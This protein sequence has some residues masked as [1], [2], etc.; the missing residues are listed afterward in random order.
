MTVEPATLLQYRANVRLYILSIMEAHD[1][2]EQAIAGLT[3]CDRG[4][5]QNILA[6]KS[7]QVSTAESII[8]ALN[9]RFPRQEPY[10]AKATV[11]RCW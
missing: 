1:L 5:I 8:M 11:N 10:D 3:T 9:Q 2:S 4:T 7:F 6:N